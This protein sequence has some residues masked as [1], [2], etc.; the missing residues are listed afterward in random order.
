MTYDSAIRTGSVT[1]SVLADNGF[2]SAA[3]DIDD[4]QSIAAVRKKECL[5]ILGNRIIRS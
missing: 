2:D 3:A 4:R 1:P 5:L